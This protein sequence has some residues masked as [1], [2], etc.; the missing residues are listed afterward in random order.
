[1]QRQDIFNNHVM[2]VCEKRMEWRDFL[3]VWVAFLPMTHAIV[4][5]SRGSMLA[6]NWSFPD[7][8]V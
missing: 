8:V 6:K 1:M 7:S 4:R 5:V 2:D 3:Q